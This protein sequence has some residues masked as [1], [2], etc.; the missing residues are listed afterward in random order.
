MTDSDVHGCNPSELR[1]RRAETSGDASKRLED[2]G[3]CAW[4]AFTETSDR[5][6]A[7]GVRRRAD[8]VGDDESDGSN[9]ECNICLELAKDPVVTHCGHLYCWPCLFRWME[10]CSSSKHC[11]VCKLPVDEN[12][13]VPLY[14]RGMVHNSNAARVKCGGIPERPHGMRPQLNTQQSFSLSTGFGLLPIL[15][16]SLVPV[17]EGYSGDAM[18]PD[19]QQQIFLSRLLLFM[20]SL[21]IMCLLIF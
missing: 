12:R 4:G 10:H 5:E 15:G 6:A 18:S 2:S 1:N 13:V 8:E 21:V 17:D 14:G 19:R 20:G 7:R 11:P 9:F 16:L 3:R